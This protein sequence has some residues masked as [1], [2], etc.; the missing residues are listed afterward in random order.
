MLS[1]TAIAMFVA[2]SGIAFAASSSWQDLG[3]GKA[4]VLAHLNPTTNKVSGVIDVV[5]EDGWSTYWRYPGSSG[6]PPRFDFS[7][8][9]A[10]SSGEVHFPAPQLITQT[11]GSYAGYKK[12]VMFPFEG[13]LLSNGGA[14]IQL[15]LL[16]GICSEVCI[17][18]QA[19]FEIKGSDLFQSDPEAVQAVSFAKITIPKKR[20]AKDILIS[21]EQE[22]LETLYIKTKHNK[23]YGKPSMFV[24]GPS[25]WFLLPA[26]L[27]TQDDN[28]AT[29]KLDVSRAPKD[30]DIMSTTLRYTL[31]TGT[32]GVEIEH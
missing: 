26:E 28:S 32:S 4:R 7:N 12:K 23:S 3:G 17:P 11:Y 6:I 5:L 31:V 16:I 8:S 2:S 30:A 19:Q 1:I 15:D 24:E 13:D 9:I 22:N 18:A 10:F 14:K 21:K 29:F 27:M 20:N 25:N